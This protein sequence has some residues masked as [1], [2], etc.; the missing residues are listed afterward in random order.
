MSLSTFEG[1]S[2]VYT[3]ADQ[4]VVINLIICLTV[5][6]TLFGIAATFIHEKHS[7]RNPGKQ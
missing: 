6:A 1:A 5:A 2:I 4:P 3:F 7:Y